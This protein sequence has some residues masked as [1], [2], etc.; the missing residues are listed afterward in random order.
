MD[1]TL[2]EIWTPLGTFE[3]RKRFFSGK[4]K[5][6][7]LKSLTLH[8]RLG[9]LLVS[10]SGVPGSVH[11]LTIAREHVDEIQD[12]L[13]KDEEEQQEE[14]ET[15]A[16]LVDTGFVG[17][18]HNLPLQAC[19]RPRSHHRTAQLHSPPRGSARYLRALV[20]QAQV[21]PPYP[22]EQVPQ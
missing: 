9:L 7:G 2:Q 11:D 22:G 12:F 20:R 16:V 19:R 6:Y 17:L 18:E 10:W 5:L 4:H 14:G 13:A 21:A 1:A 8:N 15:W 3:E